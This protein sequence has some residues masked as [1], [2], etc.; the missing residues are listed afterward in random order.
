MTSTSCHTLRPRVMPQAVAFLLLLVAFVCTTTANAQRKSH[1]LSIGLGGGVT[2]PTGAYKDAV[3][4]GFNGQGYLLVHLGP[5]PALRFN[6]GYQKFNYKDALGLNGGTSAILSG[7]G[8]LSI[9]LINGPVRPYITAGLGAFD[10]RST[11]DSA[12]G[13]TTSKVNFGIDGGAGL[14]FTFGRIDAFVEG[15]VQNVYTRNSGIINKKSI[16]TVPLSFG[17][18]VG[19]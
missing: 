14:A 6:I 8:G 17:I 19:L 15:R 10:V 18:L 16:Q 7:T 5:L 11:I 9:N 4:S 13:T 2:V 3:K 1:L 12:T